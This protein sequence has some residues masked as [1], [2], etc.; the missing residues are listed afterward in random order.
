MTAFLLV[1]ELVALMVIV[2]LSSA[3]QPSL[4]TWQRIRGFASPPL[5]GFA[6]SLAM[7]VVSEWENALHRR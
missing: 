4:R 3:A 5:D 6:F 2:T 1:L 7:S